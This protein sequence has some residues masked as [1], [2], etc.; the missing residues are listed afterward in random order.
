MFDKNAPYSLPPQ[1]PMSMTYFYVSVSLFSIGTI[2]SC[3]N[4]WLDRRIG[5]NYSF[6]LDILL[7]VIRKH[8]EIHR[9]ARLFCPGHRMHVLVWLA[10]NQGEQEVQPTRIMG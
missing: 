5:K 9:S 4:D 7:S 6:S 2:I 10:Y 1:I 8:K 3:P